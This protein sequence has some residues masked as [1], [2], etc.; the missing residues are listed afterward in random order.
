MDA[1]EA[2]E[3]SA[4]QVGDS[5]IK[6]E[7]LEEEEQEQ[8]HEQDAYEEEEEEEEEEEDEDDFSLVTDVSL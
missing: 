1:L 2:L 4:F 7:E 8:D 6:V 5:L 3:G